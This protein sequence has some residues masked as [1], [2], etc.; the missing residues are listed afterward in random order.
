MSD[1]FKRM[2]QKV[3]TGVPTIPVSTD[4]RNGDW[5]DTDIYEGELYLD[6]ATS[7]LYTRVGSTIVKA[8]NASDNFANADLIFDTN[9]THDLDGNAVVYQNGFA[10]YDETTV[11][12]QN[13]TNAAPTVDIDSAASG[14]PALRLNNATD[15]LALEIASGGVKWDYANSGSATTNLT[16]R[17]HVLQSTHATAVVNLPDTVLNGLEFIIKYTGVGTCTITPDGAD[18]IDGAATLVL[19]PMESAT[20]IYSGS[21]WMIIS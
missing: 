10:I 3:G 11:V 21:D 13:T 15:S 4:H 16:E 2:I 8:G 5:L 18:T 14:Q 6:E 1:T 20:L 7:I 9:H 17:D 12:H 19:N